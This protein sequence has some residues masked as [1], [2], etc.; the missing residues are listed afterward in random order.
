MLV[1]TW[2]EGLVVSFD[3]V[4][5][6]H[7]EHTLK[8]FLLFLWLCSIKMENHHPFAALSAIKIKHPMILT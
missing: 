7:A 1:A 6:Y 5:N 2:K 8:I 4:L 3:H